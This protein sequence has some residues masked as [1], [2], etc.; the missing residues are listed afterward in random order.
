MSKTVTKEKKEAEK[1]APAKVTEQKPEPL[2]EGKRLKQLY[3]VNKLY[4][5]AWG[6]ATLIVDTDDLKEA[7]K[8]AK[9][10]GGSQWVPVNFELVPYSDDVKIFKVT[11]KQNEVTK[12]IDLE[13]KTATYRVKKEV[14]DILRHLEKLVDPVEITLSRKGLT[15]SQMTPDKVVALEVE[16]GRSFFKKLPTKAVNISFR[17][18][19]WGGSSLQRMPKVFNLMSGL[20][21]TEYVELGIITNRKKQIWLNRSRKIIEETHIEIAGVKVGETGEIKRDEKPKLR[22]LT[23]SKIQVKEL[24]KIVDKAIRAEFAHIT[25]IK[26]GKKFLAKFTAEW[27]PGS[28]T[29]PINSAA[30]TPSSKVETTYT[31]DYLSK[32]LNPAWGTEAELWLMNKGPVKV[33]YTFKDDHLEAWIAP[34]LHE[35]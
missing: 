9:K 33:R 2:S 26:K 4:A 15:L 21:S 10:A 14:V 20:V 28:T 12:T 22:R 32:V 30:S 19:S 1:S 23:C 5:P 3:G 29:L 34:R 31:L 25:F 7:K 35:R 8:R 17:T 27:K 6:D 13:S 24:K 11:F 18:E 16:L